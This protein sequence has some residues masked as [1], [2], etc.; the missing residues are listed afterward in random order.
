MICS[1]QWLEK[2]TWRARENVLDTK[3]TTSKNLFIFS[4]PIDAQGGKKFRQKL[5]IEAIIDHLKPPEGKIIAAKE[6]GLID[7]Q[8]SN[9]LQ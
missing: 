8:L 3:W 6:G 5:E 2:R 1:I 7:K 4:D 9:I